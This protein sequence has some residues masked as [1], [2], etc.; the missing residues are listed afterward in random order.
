MLSSFPAALNSTSAISN[1][2]STQA[3]LPITSTSTIRKE[4]ASSPARF[5]S[6]PFCLLRPPLHQ[7]SHFLLPFLIASCCSR[8]IL[9]PLII[10]LN[11]LTIIAVITEHALSIGNQTWNQPSNEVMTRKISENPTRDPER[12]SRLRSWSDWRTLSLGSSTWQEKNAVILLLR[13]S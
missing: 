10:R 5:P 4:V 1:P 11:F 2:S 13:F 3:P 6:A 9:A 7:C 12:F 8:G